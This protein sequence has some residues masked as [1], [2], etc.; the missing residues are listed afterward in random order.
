MAKSKRNGSAKAGDEARLCKS[1]P[2]EHFLFEAT[3]PRLNSLSVLSIAA[4]HSCFLIQPERD[5]NTDMIF[6]DIGEISGKFVDK[7]ARIC[8]QT[9]TGEPHPLHEEARAIRL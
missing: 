9:K 1:Q 2:E 4:T 3:N 5:F 6:T 7:I 8:S